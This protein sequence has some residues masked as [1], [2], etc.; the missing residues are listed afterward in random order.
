MIEIDKKLQRLPTLLQF[1]SVSLIY[2]HLPKGVAWTLRDGVFR[3]R[4]L[5]I[6]H[7]LEDP[8]SGYQCWS[9]VLPKA[10]F[11]SQKIR[12]EKR[13][14]GLCVWFIVVV[15]FRKDMHLVVEMLFF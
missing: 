11:A 10:S 9:L 7:P 4:L 1:A 13:K 15:F 2:Q 5:S 12:E 6:Q 14:N 3:H 8:G